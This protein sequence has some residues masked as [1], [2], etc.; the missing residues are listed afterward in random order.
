MN[1]VRTNSRQIPVNA[2]PIH[3]R[4][5]PFC[6]RALQVPA[7][8]SYFS[9]LRSNTKPVVMWNLLGT[10]RDNYRKLVK[11]WHP[12][13]PGGSHEQMSFINACYDRLIELFKKHGYELA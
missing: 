8:K 11:R 6:L 9:Q 13:R 7:K 5:L 4:D 12:D 3:H 1:F 10:A 2:R